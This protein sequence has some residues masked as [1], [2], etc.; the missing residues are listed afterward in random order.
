MFH[1]KQF[2][3]KQKPNTF[4]IGT[5]SV[6]LGSW[7]TIGQNRI[8]DVGTGTGIISLMLAQRYPEAVIRALEIDPKSTELASFNFANSKF[9]DRL[10]CK[11]ED[12]LKSHF[13]DKIDH[14]I[15]NPPYFSN[16]T[17]SEKLSNAR[18]DD[19]MPL[20]AFFKK[21][22]SVLTKKGDIQMILPI[23]RFDHVLKTSEEC[24]FSLDR[25][26][27]VKDQEK[28][29]PKRI[30][31][32]FSFQKKTSHL[33]DELILKNEDGSFHEQYKDLTNSFHPF[34]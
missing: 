18:H 5:D 32:R 11:N 21:S 1:F 2:S 22:V 9:C 23:Q 31:A 19:L 15:S 12:F 13:R 33:E 20:D 28:S 27:K 30:L 17:K 34:L 4:K 8:L 7:A 24:G 25:L 29:G 16:S 6:L 14:I 3:V 10:S 26:T